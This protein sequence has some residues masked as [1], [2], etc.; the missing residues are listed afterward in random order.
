[1]EKESRILQSIKKFSAGNKKIEKELVETIMLHLVQELKEIGK[2]LNNNDWFGLK[3][4]AHK[5][6][7][8]FVFL[9][10]SRAIELTETIKNTAG[11]YP[12]NTKK[13][14]SELI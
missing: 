1:M 3:K 12:K 11:I 13:E 7:S 4:I 9:E 5:L 2:C 10:I 6:T 8:T 14:T